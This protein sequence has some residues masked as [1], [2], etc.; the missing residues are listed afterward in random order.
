M[1]GYLLTENQAFTIYQA[2]LLEAADAN[3]KLGTIKRW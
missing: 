2:F 3:E 1:E